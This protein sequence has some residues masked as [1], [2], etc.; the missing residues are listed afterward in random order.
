[1]KR[2]PLTYWP[3]FPFTSETHWLVLPIAFLIDLTI[4]DPPNR[5]HPVAWMGTLI[6]FL[7]RHTPHH[8]WVAQFLYGSAIAVGGTAIW[9]YLV[10]LLLRLHRALPTILHIVLEAFLLKMT[11]SL[12]G[13]FKAGR[14]V[15]IPLCRGDLNEARAQLAWHLVSRDTTELSES[16]VAAATIE[17]LAENT[18]D[19]VI[20]PLFY[21]AI[22][23]LP[24]AYAYRYLNTADA[25]L[26]YRDEAREW[27]GKVPARL[28]DVANL[29]PSRLTALL[30]I[31]CAWSSSGHIENAWRIWQRDASKTSSPNAG[32]PMAATAGVLAVELEKVDHYTLGSGQAFAQRQDIRR[33]IQLIRAVATIA[34]TI[35][36]FIQWWQKRSVRT[37]A[38]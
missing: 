34:I 26:G 24:A 38:F 18:S 23:G 10:A 33:A 35:G 5:W 36:T 9:A 13:L 11:F 16:Q 27:L 30:M 19:G 3:N 4:G 7:Q 14:A 31:G 1:M 29:I 6:A 20:A 17:S 21:Y 15:E 32:H 12:S 37:D 8:G 25:M 22:G 2:L 28:D